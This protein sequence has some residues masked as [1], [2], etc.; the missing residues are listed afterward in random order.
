MLN[1]EHK[2]FNLLMLEF[3]MNMSPIMNLLG[4]LQTLKVFK[5]SIDPL[6]LRTKFLKQLFVLLSTVAFIQYH[7]L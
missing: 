5:Y 2:Q 4:K 1:F 3:S 6:I 7:T